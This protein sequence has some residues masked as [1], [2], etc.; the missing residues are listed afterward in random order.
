MEIRQVY[1]AA[2][3]KH[4]QPWIE[5]LQSIL[6]CQFRNFDSVK[7][8]I[9]HAVV[10]IQSKLTFKPKVNLELPSRTLESIIR[11]KRMKVALIERDFLPV[12]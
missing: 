12:C 3:G 2:L 7:Q 9:L 11:L 4:L 1:G 6:M 10:S 5:W 8:Q